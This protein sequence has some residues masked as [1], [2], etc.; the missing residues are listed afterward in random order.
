MCAFSFWPSVASTRELRLASRLEPSPE[1]L[2]R[3]RFPTKNIKVHLP[4]G[5]RRH[6][7]LSLSL[8][9]TRGLAFDILHVVPKTRPQ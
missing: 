3:L 8:G 1:N 4:D 7:C 9:L 6:G 5:R 2:L